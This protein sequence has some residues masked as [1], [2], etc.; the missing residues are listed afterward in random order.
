MHLP[1]PWKDVG[2][3]KDAFIPKRRKKKCQRRDRR[4][5]PKKAK[6]GA[7]KKEKS[8]EPK[9]KLEAH[10]Q[11]MNTGKEWQL[12]TCLPFGSSNTFPED[13]AQPR[14]WQNSSNP[15]RVDYGNSTPSVQ[16]T[17]EAHIAPSETPC[18]SK[19]SRNTI[20]SS[21][22]TTSW[23]SNL[24]SAGTSLSSAASKIKH[25]LLHRRHIDPFQLTPSSLSKSATQHQKRNSKPILSS[26][27][28]KE[29]QGTPALPR[30]EEP[31]A[32]PVALTVSSTKPRT[33]MYKHASDLEQLRER[34]RKRAASSE[35]FNRIWESEGLPHLRKTLNENYN[36]DYSITIQFNYTASKRVVEVMTPDVLPS[37]VDQK[38]KRNVVSCF[39]NAQQLRVEV[40]FLVGTIRH[41]AGAIHSSHAPEDDWVKARNPSKHSVP[42]CGDSIGAEGGDSA[43]TL[44]PAVKLGNNQGWLINWH[45]FEGILNWKDLRRA[46]DVPEQYLV[47]PAPVDCQGGDRPQRIAKLHAHSGRMFQTWRPS[48]SLKRFAT[49]I[50]PEKKSTM[51]VVT[52]WAFCVAHGD[53]LLQNRLRYA[54]PGIEFHDVS[55]LIR[56]VFTESPQLS[57]IST[58]GRTSGLRYAVVCETPAEIHQVPKQPTREWYLEKL[59]GIESTLDWIRGGPGVPG[60]SGAAVVHDETACLLGQIWG[61]NLYSGNE[62]DPRVTYFTHIMDIFDDIRERYPGGGRLS[63]VLDQDG[64]LPNINL[65]SEPSRHNILKSASALETDT[66]TLSTSRPRSRASSPNAAYGDITESPSQSTLV[67]S[68]IGDGEDR[69]GT[70]I[71]FTKGSYHVLKSSI[72]DPPR[73][74]A[75]ASFEN[76]GILMRRSSTV[77]GTC[78]I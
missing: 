19:P 52:D 67:R 16:L 30:A 2:P 1:K 11:A 59:E 4:P 38:V 44:G 53:D 74:V 63:L 17:P 62:E 34:L 48:E 27:I 77:L 13:L 33:K 31:I 68:I 18:S 65:Y 21:T 70:N 49:A 32:T 43:A 9:K 14:P 55:E 57:V 39:E 28:T 72:E 20:Q 64:Q 56:G 10:P 37:G 22:K 73:S 6:K 60:D 51:N 46:S 61:R 75:K 41:T 35:D 45:L 3:I 42:V 15:E 66:T 23:S 7:R 58:A 40:Q 76:D 12:G 50:P 78:A 8:T 69:H 5:K 25:V 47:H 71:L 24:N 29:E 54:P 36:G 26:R